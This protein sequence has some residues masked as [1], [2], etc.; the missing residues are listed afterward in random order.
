MWAHWWGYGF[1]WEAT[2]A[3]RGY[4]TWQY[5][6]LRSKRSQNQVSAVLSMRSF[7]I[8]DDV[9]LWQRWDIYRRGPSPEV[10]EGHWDDLWVRHNKVSDSER[11]HRSHCDI[12]FLLLKRIF[13][14]C[15]VESLHQEHLAAYVNLIVLNN[16]KSQARW[17]FILIWLRILPCFALLSLYF[18]LAVPCSRWVWKKICYGRWITLMYHPNWAG[19]S[20]AVVGDRE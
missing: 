4:I 14:V 6:V 8:W 15:R 11:E 1:H 10:T 13:L 5:K 16:L 9:W 2:W 7:S 17:L 19:N 20:P 18:D 3:L 12:P